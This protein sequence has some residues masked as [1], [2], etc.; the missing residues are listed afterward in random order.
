MGEAQ[1]LLQE[2]PEPGDLLEIFRGA[3]KH[4]ALCVYN[5]YV[6]HLTVP[7]ERWPYHWGICPGRHCSCWCCTCHIPGGKRKLE[8]RRRRRRAPV[9]ACAPPPRRLCPPPPPTCSPHLAA[10]L[11]WL[12]PRR[13]NG[14]PGP[15]V[16]LGHNGVCLA[17]SPGFGEGADDNASRAASARLLFSLWVSSNHQV[18]LKKILCTCS[19]NQRNWSS[20]SVNNVCYGCA[21]NRFGG[22]L[23]ASQPV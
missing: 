5:G 17:G 13:A 22:P 15:E 11:S 19:I 23:W 20:S 6:V 2:E 9:K 14:N 4:W 18:K 1:S 21:Q 12:T 7:G 16:G 8:G 3:Y 10:L